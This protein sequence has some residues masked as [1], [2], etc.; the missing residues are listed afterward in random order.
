MRRIDLHC[1]LFPPALFYQQNGASGSVENFATRN[2]AMREVRHPFILA[3]VFLM[4]GMFP[5]GNVSGQ[6]SAT[7]NPDA[8]GDGCVTTSDLVSLLGVFMMCSEWGAVDCPDSLELT[9]IDPVDF[10]NYAYQ[11]VLIGS[12]CW[13]AENLRTEHY[14]NGDA[15]P[16]N[17]NDSQWGSTSTGATT[18]YGQ[19]DGCSEDAP[20]FDACDPDMALAEYGRLYNW[21]AVNDSRSLCPEGWHVPTDGEWT[22]LEDYITSQGFDGT[23]GTALKSTTGWHNNGNG[24]DDFGFSALPGGNRSW[25]NGL[26][27]GA[28]SF[29]MW[30]TS[31]PFFGVRYYRSLNQN[32][33]DIYRSFNPPENGFSVRCLKDAE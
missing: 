25:A 7:W 16:A 31:T 33:P 24:T 5:P 30:W 11:T 3:V 13:F 12:Q 29:A 28:G 4:L 26:F 8:N 17:L 1:L 32:N 21:H 9:C 2:L 14:A 6:E 22:E 27:G 23:E 18:I 15:I 19:E 20:D 10:D